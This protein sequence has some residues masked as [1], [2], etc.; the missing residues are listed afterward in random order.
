MRFFFVVVVDRLEIR[1]LFCLGGGWAGALVVLVVVFLVLCCVICAMGGV[2]GMELIWPH[3]QDL[4]QGLLLYN[5]GWR[6]SR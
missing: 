5:L 2:S 4:V 3:P 6:S 1:G